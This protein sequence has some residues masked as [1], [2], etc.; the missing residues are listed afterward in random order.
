MRQETAKKKTIAK[1]LAMGRLVQIGMFALTMLLVGAIGLMVWIRPTYSEM[2]KRPLKSFPTLGFDTLV[3]GDFFDEVNA[4]YEDTFPMRESWV[5][6]NSALEQFYGSKGTDV[7]GEVVDRVDIPEATRPPA[8]TTTTTMTQTDTTNPITDTTAPSEDI[9]PPSNNGAPAETLGAILK[10]GS[11]AFEYYNFSQAQADRYAS[12]V[13]RVANQLSGQAD[14]YTVVIPTSIEICLSADFRATISSDD[15]KAAINYHYGSM[16]ENVKTVDAYGVLQNAVDNGE[17]TY[18]RTDHHWTAVGAYRV[19]EAYCKQAGL[20][21]TPLADFECKEFPNY[22]GSFYQQTA[23]PE[24]AANPD[25]VQAFVPP[26]TNSMMLTD[27]NGDTYEYPIIADVTDWAQ[28][29]K[30]YTFIGSDNPMC[31]IDNPNKEDGS[32]CMLIKES[33]GNAFAPFLTENYDKVYV[34]D[35][36]YFSKIDD[37][38]VAQFVADNGI[39]DVLFLNNISATRNGGLMDCLDYLTR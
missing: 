36:R 1:R 25:V 7:Y 21:P 17:Y 22:L 32:A 6:L 37:R 24:M 29:G 15:Q 10:I 33:F 27:Q 14:V 23:S 31:V 12:F 28:S 26:S 2:E 8:T 38:N 20:T 5:K 16:A 39:D 35:Y 9:K 30:Y 11:N 34:V 13:S 3:S 18:F 19:Y 4:W